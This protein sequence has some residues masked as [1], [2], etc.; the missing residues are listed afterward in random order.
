[1]EISI[2]APA[3][4]VA[5]DDLSAELDRLFEAEREALLELG[6]ARLRGLP[7]DAAA[8]QLARVRSSIEAAAAA[9][10]LL[11]AGFVPGRSR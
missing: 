9:Q 4:L 5:G 3:E 11:A 10:R 6:R 7:G 8:K 2:E 1:M